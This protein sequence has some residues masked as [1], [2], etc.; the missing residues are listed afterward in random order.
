ML[1]QKI[2]GQS[3]STADRF[4]RSGPFFVAFFPFFPLFNNLETIHFFTFQRLS[5]LRL[6]VIM[7]VSGAERPDEI[8]SSNRP[9]LPS[10]GSD[11]RTTLPPG[12]PF[13]IGAAGHRCFLPGVW[14]SDRRAGGIAPAVL[15]RFSRISNR[16]RRERPPCRSPD[17]NHF[18]FQREKGP[19]R[20]GRPKCLGDQG[21]RDA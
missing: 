13:V 14:N 16:I 11:K 2:P 20:S 12:G 17:S 4:K 21:F 7:L 3:I 1:P 10:P 18:R 9:R 15:L 19:P 8:A 6:F 5:K